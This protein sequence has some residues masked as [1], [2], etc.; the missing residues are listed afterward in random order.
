[1][2]LHNHGDLY[3]QSSCVVW[4]INCIEKVFLR[5]C[6]FPW[7]DAACLSCFLKRYEVT[8]N[9]HLLERSHTDDLIQRMH[10]CHASTLT[11]IGVITEGI[12]STN[13]FLWIF[14]SMLGLVLAF[15][16][17]LATNFPKLFARSSSIIGKMN[18]SIHPWS[19]Y[20]FV[21]KKENKDHPPFR[22]GFFY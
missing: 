19:N 5:F 17:L 15:E 3:D 10:V 16:D 11:C 22:H 1:M 12:P 14:R 13:F 2:N 18:W 6:C 21:L 4:Y 7:Q 8:L 20:P 9:D